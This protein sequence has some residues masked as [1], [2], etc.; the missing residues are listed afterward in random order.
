MRRFLSLFLL[1][2]IA[3]SLVRAQS[4]HWEIADSG[5]P[6]DLQLVY[7]DC[8]PDGDPQ[9]PRIEGTTLAFTGRSE[10]TSIV[11]FSMS[12]STILG[13]R[14]RSTKSGPLS[15]PSFTVQTD[16]GAMR[17][18]AFTGGAVRS[19]ADA[20]V[21]ST[22]DP[23]TR[24]VWAGEV[25]PLT[26]TLDVAR[27][28]FNQLGTNIE[29]NASPLVAED[30]S[31]FEPSEL[32]AG[33]EARLHITSK[34]RA[35]AKTPG[36]MT[37]N[38]A[39][40]LVNL[41][42]GS[43][44][45]G[46]FQTPRIEQL[47]VTSNRPALVVREL[48]SPAPAGFRGAV[49]QFKLTS[50]VVPAKAAVGEPV[51]WTLE[52]SGSGNWPDIAGLPQRDVSKD[53]N[54]VQPQ[55]RR[56][57][58][59]GKLFEATLS[60]DVVLVPTRAGDYTLGPLD[61]VYF[62]PEAGAYKTISAPRAQVT[63]SPAP[64]VAT[65]PATTNAS[66]PSTTTSPPKPARV[67]PKSPAAPIGIPRDP[68]LGSK[69]A[70]VPLRD[71]TLLLFVALPFTILPLLW[72]W[73]AIRRAR[74]RDPVR[75]RREARARLEAVLA[76]LAAEKDPA[77]PQTAQLLLR[78]QHDTAV[79]WEIPQAAPASTALPDA[80]WSTL[81]VEA[82]RALYS[83]TATLPTDWA[84]RA[85][86]ALAAKRVVGFRPFT[87]LR[88]SNLLPFVAAVGFVLL[89]LPRISGAQETN[90]S[91]ASGEHSPVP[92]DAAAAYRAGDFT[93]AEKSWA[94][95][96]TQNPT[97]S[98]ARH[99]LSLALAQQDRWGEAAAHAAASFLQDPANP[100]TRWQLALSS[101]K[102]GYIP[103][104]LAR[105]FPAGPIQSLA[106]LAAPGTWQIVLISGSLVFALALAMFLYG[107]YQSPSRVRTWSA[108]T[109]LGI[110][111]LL[112]LAA[113]ASLHA[114]GTGA[115]QRAVI[116]WH[117]GTLRSIPTEADTTQKTTALPAG[118]VAIEDKTF[119]GW[120]RL[121]FENGQT[122]W[123]R[124]DDV[125]PLWR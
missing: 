18:P 108:F 115:D 35:Y 10:Q 74:H 9:L 12:R 55:A 109:T 99:N 24:T 38:A 41:Q 94:K 19:A 51:T 43:I 13:Y 34:T 96:V 25:F 50:K 81:W 65:P 70:M 82:D 32:M 87:A 62:D 17:V 85:A 80:A 79:L 8:S 63:I 20:N 86:A 68:L 114:Y 23:G 26:Y 84:S 111:A 104:P 15:I 89:V 14:A 6:S 1:C 71:R 3:A 36:P 54:V 76:Q 116:A 90:P 40:Q 30:W 97:D 48:P 47:S 78:W 46:L 64:V 44:G 27:R 53:F 120:I 117:A 75:P 60:E 4:V 5:D 119:L 39:T 22:L 92:A 58:A 95:V 69:R 123:V 83:S 102:A 101:E 106:S 118:S 56:T 52:L 21:T 61:F 73:L 57:Q 67:E 105:F 125:I 49:G 37:L 103:A 29:W 91:D 113:T 33:G 66:E 2:T 93:A 42:S 121:R 77:S 100:P 110:G 98:I 112:G 11:N 107:M 31:K 122:G 72:G 28:S 45:F 59:E 88:P 124:R 16:K 7:Q